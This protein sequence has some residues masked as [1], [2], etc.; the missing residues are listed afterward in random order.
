[1]DNVTRYQVA[2]SP[3]PWQRGFLSGSEHIGE[4]VAIFDASAV[5]GNRADAVCVLSPVSSVN[6]RDEANTAL[7][8]RAVNAHDDLVAALATIA[9]TAETVAMLPTC[10]ERGLLRALSKAARDAL[11]KAQK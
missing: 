6:A 7:I 5:D 2:H 8:L 3:L 9:A 10:G 4:S 1:M 11:T